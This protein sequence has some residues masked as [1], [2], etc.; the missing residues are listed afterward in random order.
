[1]VER[2]GIIVEFVGLPGS[3]K[4]TNS[5]LFAEQLRRVGLVVMVRED[6][7]QYIKKLGLPGKLRLFVNTLFLKGPR[8]IHFTAI[9]ALNRIFSIDAIWRYLKI[10]FFNSA[11]NKFR[12]QS[13]V[14]VIILDQ[15]IIQEIWSATIFNSTNYSKLLKYMKWFYFKTDTVI[16]FQTDTAT[17]VKRIGKRTN[18]MSRFDGMV[19]KFCKQELDKYNTYLLQLFDLSDCQYKYVYSAD[20]LPEYNSLVFIKNLN[21][22]FS[23]EKLNE[24]TERRHL[25][26][27]YKTLEV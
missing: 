25:S 6:L 17:S 12:Q 2:K 23:P 11:L 27:T 18:G 16:Y 22:F 10:S 9:L 26:I 1:M 4:T 19:P 15:W 21:V 5:L 3:G 8:V 7:K 24:E 20:Q 14:D 13:N